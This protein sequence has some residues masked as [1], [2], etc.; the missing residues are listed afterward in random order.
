MELR[1]LRPGVAI[2]RL[3]VMIPKN[4]TKYIRLKTH[5]SNVIY[6]PGNGF[7]M[8]HILFILLEN[9]VI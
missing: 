3:Q 5:Q 9:A 8:I 2:V 6:I 7:E 1:S 4:P